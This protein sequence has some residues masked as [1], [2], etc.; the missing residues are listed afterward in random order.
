MPFALVT[1]TRQHLGPA[2]ATLGRAGFEVMTWATDSSAAPAGGPFD[3]YVQLPC[4]AADLPAAAA[5]CGR[6]GRRAADDLV[7]R[8]DALAAVAARLKPNAS[9]L[10][11]V[12]EPASSDPQRKM[13]PAD[14]LSAVALALL[15]DLGRPTSR[16][17]VVPVAALATPAPVEQLLDLTQWE[18]P[19][20]PLVSAP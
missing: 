10:L 6:P 19:T 9:I 8:T 5:T 15:E 3:C 16:L 17:A 4:T 13:L 18:M 12:D 1:G 11:A 20:P 2:A 14:L 7:C